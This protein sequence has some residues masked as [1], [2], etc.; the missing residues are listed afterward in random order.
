M[1]GSD[2]VAVIIPT[3]DR[4]ALLDEAIASALQQT[5]APTEIIV[6]DDGSAVPV[7][8]NALRERHGPNFR[9]LRNTVS[10]GLAYSRNRG[11]EECTSHYIIHL[12]DDDLLAHTAIEGC[13]KASRAHPGVEVWFLG[14]KGFGPY[15]ERFNTVQSEG[16]THVCAE[17]HGQ[18]QTTGIILF[19][20]HLFPAL[21]HR[22]PMAFQRVFTKPATWARVSRL[23]WRAYM[24]GNDLIELAAAKQ[25]ITGTLRDS[26]WARYAAMA[27][28]TSG[29]IDQ[30]LYLQ[31]CAGQ[32]YSSQSEKIEEHMLQGV[33]MMHQMLAAADVLPELREWKPEIREGLAQSHFDISYHYARVGDHLAAWKHL[34]KAFLVKPSIKDLR[35]ALRLC[36][37]ESH[38]KS[39]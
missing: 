29:L 20:Q 16:V 14:V 2:A 27:C 37:G 4:P 39:A 22:V 5:H 8:E 15:S 11:V 30:V 17:A 7:D 13:L 9:L 23:R 36:L 32:G 28:S 35:L 33:A 12:D 1:P 10:Q 24:A 31:R 3:K 25:T 6:I 34:R 19:D 18:Q 26:E 38:R 21:L